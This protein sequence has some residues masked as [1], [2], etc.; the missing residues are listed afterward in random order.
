M[1]TNSTQEKKLEQLNEE[2][3][4]EYE[5]EEEIEAL[6]LCD[7]PINL[8]D[9]ENVDQSKAKPDSQIIETQ[10]DFDFRLWSAPFS[11]E[12]EMCVADEVFFQGQILPL[13][14][15]L[16][17]K[18][19]KRCESLDHNSL[20]EFRSNSSRSNSI[21]SQNS[22]S[23]SCSTATTTPRISKP[24]VQNHFHT[25][26]SP[27]PQLKVTFPR[28]TSFGNHCRKSSTWEFFRLGVVPA[29]EIAL[30]DLKVRS[31]NNVNKNHI[32]RSNSNNSNNSNV[33]AN[34]TVKKSSSGKRNNVFKQF[35][36]MGGDFWSGCKCSVETVQSNMVIIKGDTKSANKTESTTH[37][38]KEKVLERKR[39]KHR[40]KQGKRTMS[41]RR[42]FE[43]IKGLS[44]ASYPDHEALLSGD[45]LVLMLVTT[46]ELRCL[47]MMGLI[48][49][50][51]KQ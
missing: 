16:D 48:G 20:R 17:G 2:E 23:S 27:Q 44:H 41:P 28:Q 38:V 5:E 46:E 10:E 37:A 47:M 42:T 39:Q 4:E 24:R 14:F 40:Q 7:L 8:I 19:F 21:R 30:Q 51:L 43:W 3:E 33:S 45:N 29:P 9:D 1:A 50:P 26:P 6:S 22:S 32:G 12:S 31:T 18:Q 25:H 49:G 13:R 35:V 34:S 15:Q 11:A 36:G